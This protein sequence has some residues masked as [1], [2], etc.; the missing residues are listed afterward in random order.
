MNERRIIAL[1]GRRDEPTDAVEEY[2]RYLAGALRDRGFAMELTRVPWTERGWTTAL[3]ELRE[4]D[5]R[6]ARHMGAPA[7][8]GAGVV[9]A[10]ISLCGFYAS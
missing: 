2:C 1:L 3:R 5:A 4:R 9:R 10:R 6:V 7:I 8:H